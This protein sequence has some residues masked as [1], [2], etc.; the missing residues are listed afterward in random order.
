MGQ[1][2]LKTNALTG[3]QTNESWVKSYKVIKDSILNE[4]SMHMAIYH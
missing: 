4:K 2:I 1:F 3:F